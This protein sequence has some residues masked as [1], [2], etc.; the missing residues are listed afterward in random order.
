MYATNA[1]VDTLEGNISQ[2]IDVEGNRITC[3]TLVANR[4]DYMKRQLVE[5]Q[6]TVPTGFRVEID[7]E[8]YPVEVSSKSTYS[9][10]GFQ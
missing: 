1:K 5:K 8:R 4:I 7:G 9:A 10:I 2:F 3:N 6:I